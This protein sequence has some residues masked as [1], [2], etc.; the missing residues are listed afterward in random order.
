MATIDATE[1]K[2]RAVD[3]INDD[4]L[5]RYNVS[6]ERLM[7]LYDNSRFYGRILQ[8]HRKLN[9]DP[10]EIASKRHETYHCGVC[11][12][13]VKVAIRYHHNRTKKHLML[14][15]EISESSKTNEEAKL[16]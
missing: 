5:T 7:E 2:R 10:S 6:R 14:L 1:I 9:S 11:D 8:A 12:K 16:E 4:I 3:C 13:T 15:Q